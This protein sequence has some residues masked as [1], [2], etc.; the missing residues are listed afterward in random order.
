MNSKPTTVLVMRS[1]PSVRD[2]TVAMLHDLGFTVVPFGD[3]SHLYAQTIRLAIATG[4]ARRRIV[5]VTEPTDDVVRD[6]A[7]LRSGGWPVP[8]VLV[9]HDA[10][11]DLAERLGA[12]CVRDD[13]GGGAA[14]EAAI[15]HA[16]V[17]ARREAR[18]TAAAGVHRARAEPRFS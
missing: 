12:T 17:T 10:N 7:M 13:E 18:P 8:V 1:D 16:V 9:G 11:T 2:A 6:V 4:A 3:E 14:F 5:I 15:A